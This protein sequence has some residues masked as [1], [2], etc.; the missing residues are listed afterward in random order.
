MI[1]SDRIAKADKSA[2]TGAASTPNVDYIVGLY[3]SGGRTDHEYGIIKSLYIARELTNVPVLLL[4]ESSITCL[5]SE[6]SIFLTINSNKRA[7]TR[8][9][10]GVIRINNTVVYFPLE[11]R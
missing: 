11:D 3:G 9:T 6:V 4:T 8:S 7:P 1:M 10:S 2:T 5:L